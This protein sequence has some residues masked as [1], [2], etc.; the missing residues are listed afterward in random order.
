MGYDIDRMKHQAE[1]F[2]I[3]YCRCNEQ[4]ILGPNRFEWPVAPVIVNA[5]F[6]CEIYL[7][8][9]NQIAGKEMK[10][11]HL[12]VLYDALPRDEQD[13]IRKELKLITSVFNEKLKKIS[14][15]FVDWRYIFETPELEI[16]LQ[17]LTDFMEVLRG[18]VT[19]QTK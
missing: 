16:D 4:R 13:K 8:V 2:Y 5:A 11:H 3:G 17:F 19:S 15:S 7:K 10:G 18:E 14:N 12:D 1:A 9:L 6:A